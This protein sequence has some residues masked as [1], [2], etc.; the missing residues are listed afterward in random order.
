MDALYPG[1]KHFH[2]LTIACSVTLLL[3]RFYWHMAGSAMMERKWVK[4]I[5][6]V[7]DTLLLLSGISLCFLIQQFPGSSEWL[8]EKVLSVVAYILLGVFAFKAKGKMLKVFA[9]L[10]ALGWLGMIAK[11]AMTKTPILLG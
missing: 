7:I 4:I 11:V 3:V 6:H 1:M 10:G 9:V 2:M 8:T 5:P